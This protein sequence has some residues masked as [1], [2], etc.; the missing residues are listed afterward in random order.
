MFAPTLA[1]ICP[2][3]RCH[4]W[5]MKE[6]KLYSLVELTIY[7]TTRLGEA[8]SRADLRAKAEAGIIPSVKIGD[9]F[10]F[11]PDAVEAALLALAGPQAKKA[12]NKFMTIATAAAELGIT[13]DYLTQLV[14]SRT[15]PSKENGPFTYVNP[16]AV[17]LAMS[18]GGKQ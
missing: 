1:H 17:A 4:C 13:E 5:S 7:L 16:V 3:A 12:R 15:V 9:A 11:D 8:T 2:A 10:G 18:K 14:K 6:K